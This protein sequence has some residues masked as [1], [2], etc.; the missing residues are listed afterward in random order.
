MTSKRPEN[1]Q[2]PALLDVGT[3][4]FQTAKKIGEGTYGTVYKAYDSIKQKYFAVKKIKLDRL[5]LFSVTRWK[6]ESDSLML[7]RA[8][9]NRKSGWPSRN[10]T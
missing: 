5:A 4:S 6:S 1:E 7:D 3:Y 9:P 8:G 2:E 10:W